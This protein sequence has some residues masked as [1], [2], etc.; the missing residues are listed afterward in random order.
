MLILAAI[1]TP[2]VI[3]LLDDTAEEEAPN[4]VTVGGLQIIKGDLASHVELIGNTIATETVNVIPAVPAEVE[5]VLVSIGDYV[6]EGQALFTLDPGSIEDQVTQAEIGVTM[7]E[8]GVKN[9]EAGVNQASL[10]YNL[11]KSN[12]NMQL[13]SYN[14]GVNNLANYEKLYA[15]G[16]VSQMELDQVKLQASDETLSLLEKQLQQAAASISQAKLGIESAEAQ[17]QQAQEGYETAVEMLQDM[18]VVAPVS[19]YVTQSTVTESNFAS[20]AQPAMVIQNIDEIIV[21]ASV[22]ESLVS[23]VAIGDKVMVTVEAVS[24]VPFEGVVD[25][26]STSSDMRT[27]LYPLTVKVNNADR[28][29]KPGMFATV[30]MIKASSTDTLY[31]PAEAAILRDGIYYLYVAKGESGVQRVEVEVGIDNGYFVEI[32]SGVEEDAVIINKGIGLIDDN[33]TIKIIRSDQ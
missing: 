5:T 13:E 29:I 2:R 7:A 25:T 9:A 8:V 28:L 10:G 20:N 3:D 24:D 33:S 18:S 12:Y 6:E 23:K 19:G 17:L 16:V 30:D 14:F 22:T 31:V 32:L 1:A 11:A 15:E 4:L 21:N 27:L 26:L